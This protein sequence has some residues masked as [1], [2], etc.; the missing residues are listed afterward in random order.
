[1]L[2]RPTLPEASARSGA[3][4]ESVAP[5]VLWL[6][7]TERDTT[8]GLARDADLRGDQLRV[9]SPG[10]LHG[11]RQAGIS[12]MK[13]IFSVAIRNAIAVG[14][15]FAADSLPVLGIPTPGGRPPTFVPQGTALVADH[16]SVW[17]VPANGPQRG[18]AP[19]IA[20]AGSIGTIEDEAARLSLSPSEPAIVIDLGHHFPRVE[21]SPAGCLL[22][23]GR[24]VAQPIALP[25]APPEHGLKFHGEIA[26]IH[27][28]VLRL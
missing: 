14:I 2:S 12:L 10:A 9:D 17:P 16:P 21:P 24:R 5:V 4:S 13:D 7:L 26:R 6:D 11:K 22:A 18:P 15:P 20:K 8:V 19:V 1:M 3:G 23:A 25:L 27:P 28:L